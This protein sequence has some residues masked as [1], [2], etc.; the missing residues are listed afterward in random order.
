MAN[1]HYQNVLPMSVIQHARSLFSHALTHTL[2]PPHTQL[3]LQ[4]PKAPEKPLLP[5]M[6]YSRKMWE[7]LKSEGKRVWEV[8]NVFYLLTLSLSLS[9]SLHLS[10]AIVPSCV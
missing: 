6:R 5:Y 4:Q 10:C 2:P 8:I 9:L 7:Q 1:E 3:T